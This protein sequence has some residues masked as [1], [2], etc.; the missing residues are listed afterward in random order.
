M[1]NNFYFKA[2]ICLLILIATGCTDKNKTAESEILLVDVTQKYPE[3]KLRLQDIADIEYLPLETKDDFL[4]RGNVHTFTDNYIINSNSRSGDILIFN[5]QGKALKTINRQGGSNEEYAIYSNPVLDEENG[6]LF[7]NDRNKKKIFIYDLDGNYLRHMEYVS[8]KNY[9]EMHNFD[10]QRLIAYNEQ[11]KSEINNTYI[12]VS[13]ETG[14]TEKEIEIKPVDDKLTGRLVMGSG[15]EQMVVQFLTYPLRASYPDFILTEISNDTLFTLTP[16]MELYPYMIQTPPR[17]TMEDET[18]LFSAY[19]TPRYHFMMTLEKSIDL[20]TMK[21]TGNKYIMYDKE[22]KYFYTPYIYNGDILTEK[23]I[24]FYPV[25][26]KNLSSNQTIYLD[27]LEAG[28]LIEALENNE[29]Q[30]ELKEIAK[31]LD[32]EDNPVLVIA[33]LK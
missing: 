28:D 5:R 12:I 16:S 11:H 2:V 26:T 13:K 7:V 4:W 10:S 18:F 33:H 9:I 31:K 22:D 19:D 15:D 25:L 6:L 20:K 23:Q 29:L 21:G 32:E 14:V 30:G 27:E 3:K 24:Q 17:S 8:G 1:K